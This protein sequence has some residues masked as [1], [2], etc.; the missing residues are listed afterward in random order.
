[1]DGRE[2]LWEL[3]GI[4]TYPVKWD[5]E[6]RRVS[7]SSLGSMFNSP[8]SAET[9]P[10]F[11]FRASDTNTLLNFAP[12]QWTS[13]THQVGVSEVKTCRVRRRWGVGFLCCMLL[14]CMLWIKMMVWINM[15]T[16]SVRVFVTKSWFLWEV[17]DAHQ[18]HFHANNRENMSCFVTNP[19]VSVCLLSSQ[20]TMDPARQKRK[21]EISKSLAFIQWDLVFFIIIGGRIES[22]TSS[23][24]EWLISLTNCLFFSLSCALGLLWLIRTLRATRYKLSLQTQCY[25]CLLSLHSALFMISSHWVISCC[26]L[27]MFHA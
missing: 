21:E 12:V 27:V 3:R 18:T 5:T 22:E 2:L 13:S 26:F 14:C 8:S 11:S 17:V 25:V 15:N 6:P 10:D 4:E 23:G 7:A 20:H 9:F 1:M 19:H 24:L 16:A